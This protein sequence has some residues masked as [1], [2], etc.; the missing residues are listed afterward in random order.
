MVFR[1]F[2]IAIVSV[3]SLILIFVLILVISHLVNA[4]ASEAA[5]AFCQSVE[6]GDSVDSLLRKAN[7]RAIE[8]TTSE[9][10]TWKPQ[11]ATLERNGTLRHQALFQG[12][13]LNIFECDV[14]SR[15]GL[16]ISA[17][18]EEHTW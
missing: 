2:Q 5:S 14:R 7:S 13:F 9:S 17:T 1:L 10:V 11:T 6:V 18:F 12:F 15:S 4:R 16:V 8:L 3:A